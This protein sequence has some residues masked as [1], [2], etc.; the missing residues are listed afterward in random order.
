MFIAALVGAAIFISSPFFPRIYNTTPE[1][2]LIATRFLMV[3]A[4]VT[5]QIALLH[6]S[7]FT[8]RSGGKTIVTFLFDSVFMWAVSVPVAFILSRFTSLYV[9]WIFFFTRT[10]RQQSF[11]IS[12]KVEC[13]W[14]QTG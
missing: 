11:N 9:I 4:L 7:Y 12:K 1:A 5:P 2:K 13:Q 6:T 8:L 14:C 3:Q 10:S